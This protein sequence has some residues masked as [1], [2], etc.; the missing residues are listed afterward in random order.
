MCST[1][2]ESSTQHRILDCRRSPEPQPS[3]PDAK[4]GSN[5]FCYTPLTR[6][7]PA[8]ISP[9]TVSLLS[10]A[11]EPTSVSKAARPP[12]S[13]AVAGPP[14]AGAPVAAALQAAATAA[15]PQLSQACGQISSCFTCTWQ[16]WLLPP[17]GDHGRPSVVQF[18]SSCLYLQDRAAPCAAGGSQG[19]EEEPLGEDISVQLP[20][21]SAAFAR[22]GGLPPTPAAVSAAEAQPFRSAALPAAL[23]AALPRLPFAAAGASNVRNSALPDDSQQLA[24]KPPAASARLP[25][26]APAPSPRAA[27]AMASFA[28]QKA[29]QVVLVAVTCSVHVS[30][31]AGAMSVTVQ[32]RHEEV[33]IVGSNQSV[34]GEMKDADV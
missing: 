29:A 8:A 20:A 21:V 30:A 22:A 9:D 23:T 16:P 7:A 11:F 1:V 18:S 24:Q 34:G 26:A 5:S 25:F 27:A 14:P 12:C 13:D 2:G 33:S 6:G 32:N 28:A 10:R 17:K 4:T 19:D 31:A 3:T 15:G